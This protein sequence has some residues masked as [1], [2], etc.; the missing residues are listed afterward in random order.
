[1]TGAQI[2]DAWNSF[3]T[4][5]SGTLE[6][7]EVAN[8]VE[9]IL[10]KIAEEQH[11]VQN[12]LK[13][14]FDIAEAPAKDAKDDKKD[15]KAASKADVKD[16]KGGKDEKKGSGH[17]SKRVLEGVKKKV[18]GETKK[19]IGRLDKNKDGK[20]DK[21]EFTTLFPSWFEKQITEGIRGAFF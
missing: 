12:A 15:V 14:M 20:I 5:K 10:T 1:L 8:V 4:D 21:A 17:L 2:D 13:S 18:K 19:L 6:P 16:V 3:D 7:N 11:S 9:G